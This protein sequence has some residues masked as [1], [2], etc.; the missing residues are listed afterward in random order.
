VARIRYGTFNLLHGLAVDG[1]VREVDLRA[2]ARAVDAD[3]LAL[4]EVD[5]GQPRSH[6]VD[7]TAVVADELDATWWRFAPAAT[8]AGASYGGAL[9][10]GRTTGSRP[11]DKPSI[12]AHPLAEPPDPAY[13]IALVSRLPVLRWYARS[14]AAAPVWLPLHVV[15]RRGLVPVSDHP[16]VALAAVVVGPDGPFTVTSTHLSFVPGWN[17]RQLRAI[18]SWMRTMPAP[19]FILGDLNLPG[20]LPRT[21]TRWRQLARVRT[22]PSWRPRVQWDHV[23]ADGIGPGSV[24]AVTAQRLAVS[25]H[26]ALT[27][28][29]DW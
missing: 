17:V 21:V 6:K 29:L 3:V 10:R 26:A 12:P 27:V 11:G 2:S 14:F 23:L 13:G 20:A 4:Q 7:Q 9:Q 15:G 25:D 24:Q 28:D 16:R 8:G 18:A 5:R 19:R 22:Y 1:T